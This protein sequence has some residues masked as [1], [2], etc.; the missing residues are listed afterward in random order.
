MPLISGRP[1]GLYSQVIV[2]GRGASEA[3]KRTELNTS[4][5]KSEM[6]TTRD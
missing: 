2:R 3:L 5:N 1:K 6:M 4:A